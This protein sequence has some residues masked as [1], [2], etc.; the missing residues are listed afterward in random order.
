[1]KFIAGFLFGGGLGCAAINATLVPP[2]QNLGFFVGAALVFA[3]GATSVMDA[4][5]QRKSNET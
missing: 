3:G 5:A 2:G 4:R 1:M